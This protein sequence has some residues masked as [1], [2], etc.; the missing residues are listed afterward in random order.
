[1]V[2][3]LSMEPPNSV[4]ADRLRDEQVKIF[5]AI[6]PLKPE[7]VVRGQFNGYL[8][9]PGVKPGSTVETYA[10][11]RL[12]IDSWRWAGVPFF[13]RAG[14]CLPLTATEVMVELQPPPIRGL[15]GDHANYVRLRLGP[16]VNIALGVRVM[17][18]K[19]AGVGENLELAAVHL[20]EGD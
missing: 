1:V 11:V 16:H 6:K 10:A 3:Y 12:E 19:Q 8:K 7:N 20:R 18:G 2:G 4:D 17:Q 13:I 5:R 15:R 14:K 9:E